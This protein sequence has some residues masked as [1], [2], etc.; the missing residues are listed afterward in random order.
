MHKHILTIAAMLMLVGGGCTPTQQAQQSV[1]P[2]KKPIRT[3]GDV[4]AM[5]SGDLVVT[6]PEDNFTIRQADG[7][8]ISTIF[9]EMKQWG[10]AG[11]ETLEISLETPAA[12]TTFKTW[13]PS[14]ISDT[15]NYEIGGIDFHTNVNAQGKSEYYGILDAKNGTF[16][17]IVP[18][19]DMHNAAYEIMNSII[20]NPTEKELEGA[21]IIP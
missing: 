10:L 3:L 1:S 17:K 15:A 8:G 11:K 21:Q 16:V 19:S 18:S 4:W 13:A 6:V 14:T 7:G 2:D 5:S 9:I 12:P 20:F